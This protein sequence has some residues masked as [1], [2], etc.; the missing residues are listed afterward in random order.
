MN[1]KE[2]YLK[3]PINQTTPFSLPTPYSLNKLKIWE[4]WDRLDRKICHI[5]CSPC[6]ELGSMAYRVAHMSSFCRV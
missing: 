3:V 4:G 2:F 6:N 1:S 5:I